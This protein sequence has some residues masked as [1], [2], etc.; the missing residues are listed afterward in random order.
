MSYVSV[1]DA[2]AHTI[3]ATSPDRMNPLHRR[4]RTIAATLIACAEDGPLSFKISEIAEN[5]GVSTATIYKD[6]ADATDL[7]KQTTLFALKLLSADWAEMLVPPVQ[8]PTDLE[9]LRTFLLKFGETY[10]NPYSAWLLRADL[11]LTANDDDDVRREILAFQNCLLECGL[12]SL[13]DKPF[14]FDNKADILHVLIGATQLPLIHAMLSAS[15]LSEQNANA[16]NVDFGKVIDSVLSWLDGPAASL[17]ERDIRQISPLTA[18]NSATQAFPTKSAAQ[19][20]VETILA[21]P[22]KRSDVDAR[23]DRICAATMQVCSEVGMERASVTQIAQVAQVSTATIYRE[24]TDK[25]ELIQASIAFLVPTYAAATMAAVQETD[26]R[27]RLEKLLFANAV[28]LSDP[29]GAWMF[30]HYVKMEANQ[31]DEM[32]QKARESR[33]QSAKFWN[34]QLSRLEDEGAL[35]VTDHDQTRNMLFAGIHRRSVLARVL[36]NDDAFVWS[37]IKASV[38]AATDVLFGLYGTERQLQPPPM[39]NSKLSTP[40]LV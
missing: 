5:A 28:T 36:T 12:S 23:R 21:Q 20:F 9:M 35:V 14:G 3:L 34:E 15:S 24:F 38:S 26:P 40:E 29:F 16:A 18:S 13:P 30:R 10:R 2:H 8:P 27:L 25:A 7:L 4:E 33:V 6:F 1:I 19:L 39:S 31:T 37:E 32:R 17:I 11:A 22:I